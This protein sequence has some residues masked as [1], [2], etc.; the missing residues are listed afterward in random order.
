MN[1]VNYRL[2]SSW[3]YITCPC[4]CGFLHDS[5]SP[6]RWVGCPVAGSCTAGIQG[7]RRWICGRTAPRI[8][9]VFL[10]SLPYCKDKW[11][12][13]EPHD[14]AA[15]TAVSCSTSCYCANWR[16]VSRLA[17]IRHKMAYLT[18]NTTVT[19]HAN[20]QYTPLFDVKILK[21]HRT[22]IPN[23]PNDLT[24]EILLPV[25]RCKSSPGTNGR[26]F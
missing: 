19:I 13:P 26:I 2:W 4:L 7:P 5:S 12:A 3:C 9:F 14:K 15:N 23:S 8:P 20:N 21:F 24:E 6:P 17:S 1:Y 18:S 25:H 16:S 10:W 22:L 11:K